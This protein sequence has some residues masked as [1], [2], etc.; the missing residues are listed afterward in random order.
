ML[1]SGCDTLSSGMFNISA[2]V[3]YRTVDANGNASGGPMYSYRTR[4]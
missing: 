2:A 1:C 4:F 3:K